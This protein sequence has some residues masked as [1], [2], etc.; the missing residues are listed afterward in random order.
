[1]P[2]AAIRCQGLWKIFGDREAAALTAARDKGLTKKDI[3][4]RFGCVVGVANVSFTVAPG[5]IFCIMGLSGSGKSTLVRHLNRLVEPSAGAVHIAGRDINRLTAPELRELRAKNVGMVFQNMA[6]LPHRSVRDNVALSL[7]LRGV[8]ASTRWRVAEEKL[9]LVELAGWGDRFP[10]EL[11]GGM[12]QRVGLARAMAAD[13]QILLM[14]EPFS[15][16]DPLIRRQLQ[17]QFLD[18]AKIVKKTTVFITHD[19]DEAIHLGNHI[20]IMKDGEIV[21]V[22]T[23]EDIVTAPADKYVADFVAGISR[24]KIVTA[25]KIME[26][27]S[28]QQKVAGNGG[29]PVV[30]QNATL[31]ALLTIASE[32]DQP[33]LVEDRGRIAGVISKQALIRG[34]QG[35]PLQGN[36]RPGS[37]TL[38]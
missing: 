21:Q 34:I 14:D 33:I 2:E 22:G 30:Q 37:N 10:D 9:E 32:T 18:L 16:L 28:P 4:D 19:L 24:L 13:P 36:G 7:E 1:M 38:Q 31:D 3:F 11:S 26:A 17:N 25:G 20:A 15:A 35:Q 5:E 8:P 23:P 12:K 27:L 29:S 6:L